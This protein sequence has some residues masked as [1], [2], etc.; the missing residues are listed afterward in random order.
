[1]PRAVE[2][3]ANF[4]TPA[5]RRAAYLR[6]LND[7]DGLADLLGVRTPTLRWTLRARSALSRSLLAWAPSAAAAAQVLNRGAQESYNDGL[8]GT[9]KGL[10]DERYALRGF[11]VFPVYLRLLSAGGRTLLNTP[12][13]VDISVTRELPKLLA[14]ADR[15]LRTALPPVAEQERLRARLKVCHIPDCGLIYVGSSLRPAEKYCKRCRRRWTTK[16]KRWYVAGGRQYRPTRRAT[17]ND[18]GR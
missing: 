8:F 9:G 6:F 2:F 18:S 10:R 16:Q 3:K 5:R 11:V 17:N 4:S 14:R 12:P 1:M 15:L 7:P 13:P